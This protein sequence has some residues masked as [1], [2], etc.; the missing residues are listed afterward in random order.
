VLRARLASLLVAVGLV[1]PR[2]ADASPEDVF[3]FGPKSVAMGGTGA[4]SAEGMGAVYGNPA[5]LS[6]SRERSLT[7]GLF[8]AA[9][10][11]HAN[12][13]V[14][15]GALK[16]G[17]VGAVVPVPFGGSLRERVTLGLGFFTPTELI[18]RGRIL[19]PETPQFFVAD[20]TQ[21][22]AVQAGLGI[23]VGHGLRIGGGFSA[24]AA[25]SGSVLVA[26]DATG[27]IG[28]VVED[29]LVASYAP[30]LGA[31]F[32]LGDKYRAGLTFRGALEGRFDVVIRVRDLG[33]IVVPP[34][35]ISGMAQYDPM[36]LAGEIARVAGPWRA[37][38]GLTWKR[39]SAYPGAPEA[40]VRCALFDTETNT[41][42]TD[43]CAALV[44]ESPGFSD[45]FVPRLGVER[46][47]EPAADVTLHARA[48]YFFEPTPAPEQTKR[49][50][51]FDEARS[52]FTAGYG[53]SLARPL[54]PVSLEL[55]AQVHV[56]HGRTHEKADGSG[57][58]ETG[59]LLYAGG[60]TATVAF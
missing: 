33:Q 19:Y 31:T 20:R 54:P 34:L 36:Q 29:T 43:S 8:G 38:V 1:L 10:D 21:S 15:Y 27:R 58:F 57:R 48:G 23:D 40:T 6:L 30:T 22:V 2:V 37:A 14:P 49:G 46:R 44:P 39:W 51:F 25:L 5:L 26:T 17:I 56:L 60:T 55:F 9:F 47:F 12:A 13:D 42:L 35:H 45:T 53:V 7:L 50:N 24:L 18:V 4:A 52:A 16:G 28:T 3:G 41:P 59:G 11:L 32:D